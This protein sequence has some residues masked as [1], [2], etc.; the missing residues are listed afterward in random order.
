LFP[1]WNAFTAYMKMEVEVHIFSNLGEK[2]R[3]DFLESA[4]GSQLIR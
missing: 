3:L 2:D 4:K 1:E